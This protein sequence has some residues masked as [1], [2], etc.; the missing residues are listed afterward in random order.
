MEK[1]IKLSV[2]CTGRNDDYGGNF[3]DRLSYFLRSIDRINIPTEIIIVEWEPI[4]SKNKLS[5]VID[6][7][8][9]IVKFNNKIRIIEVSKENHNKFLRYYN[10]LENIKVKFQEYPGKNVGIRR[11][12]SN[13]IL[14]TNP[15]IYFTRN[16][17]DV[18][19]N[20]IQNDFNSIITCGDPR[21]C[22]I[23]IKPIQNFKSISE[24]NSNDLY[25]YLDNMDLTIG[26]IDNIIKINTCALGDFMLFKK[27][28]VLKSKGFKESPLAWTHH[29]QPFVNAFKPQNI[30]EK[31]MDNIRIFHFD[32]DRKAAD[33]HNKLILS[34]PGNIDL[35]K[36]ENDE[37]WGC[38]DYN[39]SEIII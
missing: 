22:R 39:L 35:E 31:T 13:Y 16:T 29:E 1:N 20:I 19:E 18:I 28:N 24:M 8:N 25:T 21:G 30:Y 10:I 11:A 17:L 32:H 33:G 2:V 23:D 36:I 9:K 27:E 12:N 15:D 4:E 7:W 37:N 3:L 38:F 26:N 14:Q 5:E 6:K 34:N